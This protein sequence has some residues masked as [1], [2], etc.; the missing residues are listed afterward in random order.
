MSVSVP[1]FRSSEEKLK[2][3]LEILLKYKK[4]IESTFEYTI[5]KDEDLI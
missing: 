5:F 3:I 1:T 4:E 2:G